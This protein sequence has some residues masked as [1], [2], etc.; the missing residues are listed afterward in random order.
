MYHIVKDVASLITAFLGK[1][2]FSYRAT[3][4]TDG[5]APYHLTVML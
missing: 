2:P 4:T 5:R 3:H 1:L